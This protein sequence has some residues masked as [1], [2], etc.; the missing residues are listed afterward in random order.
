MSLFDRDLV[1]TA[2]LRSAGILWV[3][4]GFRGVNFSLKGVWEFL[5]WIFFYFLYFCISVFFSGEVYGYLHNNWIPLNLN[6]AEY[7]QGGN[8]TFAMCEC[9]EV[10]LDMKDFNTTSQI[11]GPPGDGV[12][13][14]SRESCQVPIHCT[15]RWKV[16]VVKVCAGLLCRLPVWHIWNRWKISNFI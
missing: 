13:F 10:A 6:P 11:N 12:L 8:P 2:I 1:P 7:R 5:E 4:R 15:V 14:S 16:Y 9:V 3:G